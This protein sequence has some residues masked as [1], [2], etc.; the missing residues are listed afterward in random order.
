MTAAASDSRVVCGRW[1]VSSRYK[2]G[3]PTWNL[4]NTVM[5]SACEAPSVASRSGGPGRNLI[6]G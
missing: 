5:R 1:S 3:V 6:S 4:T 2:I